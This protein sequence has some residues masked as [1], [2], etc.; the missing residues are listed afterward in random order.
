MG[1]SSQMQRRISF[2]D[3]GNGSHSYD[4]QS[5]RSALNS[6]RGETKEIPLAIRNYAIVHLNL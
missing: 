6:D 4:A 2:S 5:Y 3:L 1:P